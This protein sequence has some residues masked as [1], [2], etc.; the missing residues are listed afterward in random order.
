MKLNAQQ[1]ALHLSKNLAPIYIVSGDEPL[2]TQEAV[3]LIRDAAKK[4]GFSERVRIQVESGSEWGNVFYAH[5][6]SFSLFSTKRILELDLSNAKLN[7]ATSKILQD[8]AQKPPEDSL[9]LIRANKLDSKTEQSQWY[10]ALDKNS[11]IIPI[12]PIPIEQLPAWITQRAKKLNLNITKGAAELLAE[13]VEGNLLAAA[14]EL[15]KLRLLQAVNTQMTPTTGT[16]A[17]HLPAAT[18]IDQKTIENAVIDNAHFDIFTLVDSVLAGNCQRSIRI[19]HNLAAEDTEP[20][21]IL[22]A[23][24][25]EIRTLAEMAKQIQQGVSLASLFPKYRIWEKRQPHV[26][27]FLQRHKPESCWKLQA[28]AARI[29]RIIKGA[30]IGNVWDALRQLILESAF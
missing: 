1:L 10:K 30:E 11:V 12:W 7:A 17:K 13:L 29:D 24:T 21:L 9:L 6:Q 22:W 23:F 16:S 8:Y 19:L 4:A 27:A 28:N 20:T 14:Q 5:A 18:T 3:D 15:E 26:R 2:L 25:R